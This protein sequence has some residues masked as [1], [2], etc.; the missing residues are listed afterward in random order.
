MHAGQISSA[1]TV[2]SDEPNESPEIKGITMRTNLKWLPFHSARPIT[3][4][5]RADRVPSERD[6]RQLVSVDFVGIVR[7]LIGL[8]AANPR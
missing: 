3:E 5:S 8:L 4:G 7:E 6:R 2:V 1:Q